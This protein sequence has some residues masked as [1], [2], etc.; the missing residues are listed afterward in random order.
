MR[1]EEN[2]AHGKEERVCRVAIH[3]RMIILDG[4]NESYE[5]W[6]TSWTIPSGMPI[7]AAAS[8]AEAAVLLPEFPRKS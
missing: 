4:E 1:Q 6:P 3:T 5:T 2:I 8:T 7:S